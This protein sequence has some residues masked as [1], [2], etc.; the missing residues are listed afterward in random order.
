MKILNYLQ[1]KKNNDEGGEG[2]P[3]LFSQPAN[4]TKFDDFSQCLMFVFIYLRNVC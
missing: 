2:G 4:H 3:P 1:S